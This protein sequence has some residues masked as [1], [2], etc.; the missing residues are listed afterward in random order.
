MPIKAEPTFSLKDR[1]FNEKKIKIIAGEIA[2]V[3]PAFEADRF[4]AK[5]AG[6]LPELE[7]MDRLHWIRECLHDFLPSDY[8]EAAKILKDSLPPPSDPNLTDNDF[9]SF[10]YGPYGAFVAEYGCTQKDVKFSLKI[11]KE[12][13]KRFSVEF[14]IRSFINAFPEETM[15]ELQKWAKD[16]HYHV[17]RLASEGA[18]PSLPWAKNITLDYKAPLPILDILHADKTRFVTRSVANHLNDISKV[19]PELVVKTLKRWKKAKKQN[20]KELTYI[21][22]HSLRT[23]E[24]QGHTAALKLLGYK[25]GDITVENF[26]V[27]PLVKIGATLSFTFSVSSHAKTSHNLLV[28]YHLHFKK[29]NG[30]L[31]HKTFKISKTSIEPG[32]TLEFDKQHLL[33]P[34]TTR[35]LHPG[36]HE[37]ELQI[38]GA[39][40]GRQAFELVE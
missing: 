23:L 39:T 33:R 14:P 6:K 5:V 28:D 22:K 34:M 27:S 8:R 20:K 7:L 40:Y 29:A 13:T 18:R 36:M 31:V 26:S 24:N 17:R 1:L 37:V 19:D 10:I 38:N 25:K 30:S 11:L 32:Q 4:T 21:I 16:K 12:M 15:T 35:V 2:A 3:H 9:G